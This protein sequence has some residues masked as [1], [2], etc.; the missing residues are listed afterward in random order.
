MRGTNR[1]RGVRDAL[2]HA[3]VYFC[4]VD[5]PVLALASGS[6][7]EIAISFLLPSGGREMCRLKYA[8]LNGRGEKRLV[9]GASCAQYEYVFRPYTF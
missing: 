7:S 5:S 8:F 1:A 3:R 6:C 9:K 2:M 4:G